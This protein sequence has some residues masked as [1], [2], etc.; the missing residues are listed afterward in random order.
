MPVLNEAKI[1][2]ARPKDFEGRLDEETAIFLGPSRVPQDIRARCYGDAEIL[3][4]RDQPFF[5]GDFS[6]YVQRTA[7]EPVG[8]TP[9]RRGSRLILRARLMHHGSSSR[10][11]LPARPPVPLERLVSRPPISC[12]AR[13][14]GSTKYPCAEKL[15]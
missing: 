15:S 9:L 10:A 14:P 1:R 13:N 12:S 8:Q 4:Q 2:A 7:R 5:A 11:R 6:K 3:M